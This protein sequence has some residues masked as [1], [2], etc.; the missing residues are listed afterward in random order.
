MQSGLPVS[1]LRLPYSALRLGRARVDVD[2]RAAR[3]RVVA[4]SARRATAAAGRGRVCSSPSRSRVAGPGGGA[5]VK[6]VS[7]V[8]QTRQASQVYSIY[9]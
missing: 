6:P 5:I 3:P 7:S 1:G 4:T 2:R 8:L 9:Q